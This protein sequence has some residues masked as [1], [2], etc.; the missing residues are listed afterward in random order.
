[1]KLCLF[2]IVLFCTL[3]CVTH[4]GYKVLDDKSFD[5]VVD[6][7][8]VMLF[9]LKNKN[10]LCVQIT[11]FGGRVVALWVPDRDGHFDDIVLGYPTPEGYLKGSGSYFGA[12][13]GRY[14][15]RIARGQFILN[16]R[17]YTLATNNNGNHL[18]GGIKGFNN[19][20]WEATQV[21]GQT[22]ELTY[23]S[24]DMEEG[25]PGNL[26]T[27]VVYQLTNNDELKIE[28]RA[29]T[30]APTPVNLTHHSFFNLH[31]AGNGAIK[32]HLVEINADNFTPVDSGLIPT[33]EMAQVEGTPMDFRQP[34]TI[35]SRIDSDFDQLKLGGGYDHNYVLNQGSDEMNFA[36]R[37][38]DP[39]S[40]RVLE[41]FTNEP[42]MQFYT[43]NFL[44]GMDIGK[45]DKTYEY[46]S[47]FCMETQHFPDSPNHES[48]PSTIL[49]PGQEYYSVCVYKFSVQ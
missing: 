46:R 1:M 44:N 15:N 37:V 42:G 2:G 12:T 33:G 48:F 22:L 10:D 14:G 7:K 27:T 3:S 4:V 35:G 45:N 30:D 16:D 11:N 18:H 25:Y 32:D 47:A 40:G 39:E 36:A 28:Y 17:E 26:Q 21:D 6:G 13:I 29:T 24:R 23:M 9:T 5:V 31:G 49:N 34:T 38:L 19:V 20:V 8:M 41:V 43:G